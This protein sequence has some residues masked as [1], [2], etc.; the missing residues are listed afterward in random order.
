[1]NSSSHAPSFFCFYSPLKRA[2]PASKMQ[3]PVWNHTRRGLA[4]LEMPSPIATLAAQRLSS[5]RSNPLNDEVFYEYITPLLVFVVVNSL[6][7]G[8]K[9]F[10]ENWFYSWRS[11]II[12]HYTRYFGGEEAF[13]TL[14]GKTMYFSSTSRLFCLLLTASQQSAPASSGN[15]ANSNKKSRRAP[16]MLH[17][18][19][20]TGWICSHRSLKGNAT[21]APRRAQTSRFVWPD[22]CGRCDYE[23]L[24]VC[25]TSVHL[26]S[27]LRPQHIRIEA[28][29]PNT[30]M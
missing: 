30:A 14:K 16:T 28:D 9:I 13:I 22:A 21:D 26:L 27:Q 12:M 17:R 7:V 20:S 1:M 29:W 10:A 8:F 15:A 5:W 25:R 4:R 3:M 11:L 18:R 19:R 23:N 6:L 2:L 24:K